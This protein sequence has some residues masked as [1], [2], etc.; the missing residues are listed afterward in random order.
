MFLGTD[1]IIRGNKF[2][3]VI[4]FIVLLLVVGWIYVTR[5]HTFVI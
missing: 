3:A 1:V 5:P 4:F 2:G